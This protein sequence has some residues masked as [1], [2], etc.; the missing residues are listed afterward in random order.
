MLGLAVAAVA[1]AVDRRRA[2]GRAGRL[3]AG[4]AAVTAEAESVPG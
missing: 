4:S 2:P 1:F 3:V